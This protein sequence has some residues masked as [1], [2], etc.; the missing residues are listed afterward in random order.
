MRLFYLIDSL[1]P[2]GAETSL[3]ALAPHLVAG[4]VDL[5]VGYFHDRPGLQSVVLDAGARATLIGECGGRV[6]RVKA[7]R[8]LVQM[9]QPDL[10]HTTLWEANIAGRIGARLAR[11]RVVSSIVS[12]PYGPEHRKSEHAS[13]WKVSAA[14]GLDAATAQL[15]RRFHANSAASADTM[16]RRLHV[17]RH[18]IDVVP[19]GRD[20]KLLGM[21]T[22]QRRDE[23]R[24]ALGLSEASLVL[25]VGRHDPAKGFDHLIRAAPILRKTAPNATIV[26]AGRDGN[27]TKE[28]HALVEEH[29]ASPYVRFLGHRDD[30]ADLLCAADVVVAPSRREGLP[31]TLIE[32][33]ALECPIVASDLPSIREVTGPFASLVSPTDRVGLAT[34]IGGIL[35]EPEKAAS[36]AADGRQRF[37]ERFTIERCADGMLAF[38]ERAME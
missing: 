5:E 21:R 31:G 30:I 14:H 9:R 10:V 37:L 15:V 25:A 28:L 7:V 6:G 27:S 24:S 2:G 35:A 36:R 12:D 13:P 8:R 18:L 26:M 11:T 4:G 3:A 34:A 33:L 17:Q 29:R 22:S 32:A 19:R 20:A 38:Y 1:V 16:S 23:L